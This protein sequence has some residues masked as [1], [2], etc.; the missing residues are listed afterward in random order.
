VKRAA[1]RAPGRRSVRV[2]PGATRGGG[3]GFLSRPRWAAHSRAH[4]GV[5]G[6]CG[7]PS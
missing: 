4:P 3:P 6:G 7:A 2:L 1:A 5:A